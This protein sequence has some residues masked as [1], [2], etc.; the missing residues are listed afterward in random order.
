MS[1]TDR[2]RAA[3]PDRAAAPFTGVLTDVTQL[4]ERHAAPSAAVAAKKIDRIDAGAAALIAVSPLVLVAT[5]DAEG[6]CTVSP[7]GGP[8]GF[9]RVL[10]PHRLAL[11]EAPGNRLLD[12]SHNL[13]V[14][15][16][17]GMLFVVPGQSWTLRVEGRAWLTTDPAA[18][19]PEHRDRLALGVEVRSAFVHCG[20][21]FELGQ[22]W[23]PQAWP[24]DVPDAKQV[25]LGHVAANTGRG[26]P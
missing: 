3:A 22:V 13:L 18:V 17:V 4:Q 10:D 14:N 5:C 25:F 2:P 16:Q 15:P 23:D 20:R 21:A 12:S 1:G 6:R 19:H 7:R 8:P 11:T 26:A 9:V 24:A